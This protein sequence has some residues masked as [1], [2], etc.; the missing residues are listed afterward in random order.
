MR[1]EQLSKSKLKLFSSLL[2]KKYRE[3]EG[4]FLAEGIKMA[5]EAHAAGL[6]VEAI[7]CSE[8]AGSEVMAQAQSLFGSK[9]YVSPEAEFS[10][11]TG[12]VTPEGITAVLHTPPLPALPA[13]LSNGPWLILEDLRDPG[14]LGTLIRS[15]DWFGFRGVIC[16]PGSTECFNPKALR[17]SMGSIFRVPVWYPGNFYEIITAH[18]A[19]VWVADAGGTPCTAVYLPSRQ[20]ILI[21]SESHGPSQAVFD[22][23]GIS[24]VAI[25][26]H[27]GAESL[28]AA[29]AGA[30]LAYAWR[31]GS[32]P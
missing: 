13:D 8:S 10:R 28:N 24:T 1:M 17:A 6:E 2:L 16:S 30:I 32:T 9:C 18:A 3:R 26:G 23:P 29:I 27:G 19:Q 22:T 12:Q 25:P 7:I 20:A 4:L 21:G 15:A 14:N 31:T 11:L 5:Q